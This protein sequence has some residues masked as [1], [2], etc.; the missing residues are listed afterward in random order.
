MN[1]HSFLEKEKNINDNITS[2]LLYALT[3]AAALGFN[4]LILEIFESFKWSSRIFAKTIYV[5]IMFLITIILSYYL[6]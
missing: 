4:D 1:K 6:K 2:I 5:I 3:L